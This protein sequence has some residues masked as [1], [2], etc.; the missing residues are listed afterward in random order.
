MVDVWS[1]KV[2]KLLGKPFDPS[3]TTAE[4]IAHL[5]PQMQQDKDL[6]AFIWKYALY[7]ATHPLRDRQTLE[8]DLNELWQIL[9]QRYNTEPYYIRR[10][11]KPPHES[12]SK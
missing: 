8:H 9:E 5:P 11:P 7:I 10:K 3:K 12:E 1:I 4:N 2:E 6:R